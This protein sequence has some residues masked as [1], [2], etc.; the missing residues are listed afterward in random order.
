[1]EKPDTMEAYL[2]AVAEQIRWRRARGA[3]TQEL[4]WH[5]EEQRD[6][7]SR[8]GRSIEEAERLAVAEMGDPVSVGAELDRLHRPRPQWGLL[9]LTAALFL[10]G[11]ALRLW[12]AALL[13]RA[14]PTVDPE[15]LRTL[16][17]AA[18]GCGVLAAR[19]LGFSAVLAGEDAPALLEDGGPLSRPAPLRS[20][21]EGGG[22]PDPLHHGADHH[23]PGPE[24]VPQISRPGPRSGPR[25]TPERAG[26]QG[27]S[28]ERGGT[29]ARPGP[30]GGRRAAPLSRS[31]R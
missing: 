20:P 14:W 30:A 17:A 1:M 11:T 16:G 12:A 13:R 10:A 21:T 19:A 18:L 26:G 7:F 22:A 15:P 5:L 27:P 6:A 2:A 29:R 31:I 24:P 28:S 25:R 9:A 3:V 4:R 23:H 8:E